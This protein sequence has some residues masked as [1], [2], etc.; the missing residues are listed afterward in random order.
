MLRQSRGQK[1][2]SGVTVLL[3]SGRPLEPSAVNRQ[4]RSRP[5]TRRSVSGACAVRSRPLTFAS[6]GC[7]SR[8]HLQSQGIFQFPG[9]RYALHHRRT[10][11]RLRGTAPSGRHQLDQWW[12][13]AQDRHILPPATVRL[14]SSRMKLP[15]GRS[16][17]TD[18]AIHHPFR[19]RYPISLRPLSSQRCSRAHFRLASSVSGLTS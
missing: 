2:R 6:Y 19:T 15:N 8:Q 18:Q 3:P 16:W 12:R 7:R 9:A 10:E 11:S 4:S 17:S 1:S 5:A 13:L 14:T